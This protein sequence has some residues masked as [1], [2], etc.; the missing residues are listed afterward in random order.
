M[1]ASNWAEPMGPALSGCVS[2]QVG[3]V[4]LL[5][6]LLEALQVR[7]TING[8]GLNGADIDLGRLVE[9]LTLNRSTRWASGL[10]KAWWARCWV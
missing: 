9:G 1:A 3:A 10:S 6:P 7:Q 5:Y 4:P 8:L 2:R